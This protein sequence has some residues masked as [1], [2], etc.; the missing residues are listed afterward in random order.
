MK[1]R[2]A[3]AAATVLIV[4]LLVSCNPS[5][6][7]LAITFSIDSFAA[8]FPLTVGYTIHNVSSV[9]LDNCQI[10]ISVDLNND[11][12]LDAYLWTTGVNLFAGGLN[13]ST[14][15]FNLIN[16][17]NG[18]EDIVVTGSGWDDPPNKG[19]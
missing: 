14:I 6:P 10:Q 12:S 9:S 5:L 19:L 1:L 4:G 16:S 3:F 7:D 11:G 2:H 13:S 17:V 18:F 8:G 15:D